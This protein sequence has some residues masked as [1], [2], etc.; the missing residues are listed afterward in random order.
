MSRFTPIYFKG[1]A[2]TVLERVVHLLRLG[3]R[4][5]A[6]ALVKILAPG[7]DN[8]QKF[9]GPRSRVHIDPTARVV[10]AL[11]NTASGEIWIGRYA[12]FA[13]GVSL[14]T[15]THDP[16]LT[17]LERILA[18]PKSGRD[19]MIEDGVW[20]GNGVIV[21][22]GLTVGKN[23]VVG[24][25]SVVTRDV[26]PGTMVAG[27]PARLVRGFPTS[28]ATEVERALDENMRE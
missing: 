25:G 9:W 20:L 18:V 3:H 23:A 24:A 4:G 5:L 17:G 22:G 1:E 19:I 11:F 14:I 13:Q 28:E 26:A 10:D 12:F 21:L 7:L 8:R 16:D 27:V 2:P 15:G 6:L